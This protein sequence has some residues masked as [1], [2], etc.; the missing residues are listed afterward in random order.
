MRNKLLK[1]LALM[2]LCNKLPHRYAKDDAVMRDI[3]ALAGTIRQRKQNRGQDS[4]K[5]T[6]PAK[7]YH[8]KYDNK[9]CSYCYPDSASYAF[10]N[11]GGRISHQ[12]SANLERLMEITGED[13][14]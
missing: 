11:K 4:L 7:E 12:D 9:S 13:D 10:K 8:T 3:T 14:A 1:E 5:R 6:F 2:Y